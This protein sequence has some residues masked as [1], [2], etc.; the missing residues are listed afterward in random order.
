MH[1][2]SRTILVLILAGIFFTSLTFSFY[3]RISPTTDAKAY[4]RI[5]RNLAAGLGYIEHYEN[6]GD[7]L[8]D[9]AIVRVGPGYEFF[10]AGIYWFLG[11]E[12]WS[13]IWAVQAILRVLT[14]FFIFKLSLLLLGDEREGRSVGIL[15]ALI[16]AVFPDF[17]VVGG[18]LLAETFLMFF[19]II[20]TYY[21]IKLLNT[22]KTSYAIFA[23]F[24]WGVASL[25][26][27]TAIPAVLLLAV[28]LAHRKR[29]KLA[30]V[31]LVFTI[32]FIGGWSLRNSFL[33]GR[34]LFTTTAGSYALWIGNNADATGGYDKTPQIQE[35]VS[36]EHSVELSQK[37]FRDYFAFIIHRPFKFIELQFRKTALYFSLLRPMGFWLYLNGKPI[38]R[39]ITIG[40]SGAF[41]VLLFVFGVAGV[42]RYFRENIREKYFLLG[43]VLLQPVVVIPT[44]VET[45]YRYPFY[46]FLVFFAA[47]AVWLLWNKKITPKIILWVFILFLVVSAIDFLYSGDV[48]IGRFNDIRRESFSSQM[49]YYR[50][51][52]KS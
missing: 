5:A 16:F 44:Y 28:L 30:F 14:A 47:Y 24:F 13:V 46:L 8:R 39:L 23:S 52:V 2:R 25:T 51:H 42:W 43:A 49:R 34:P 3:Y 36:K 10:L 33:Y 29:W 17:I 37:A 35:L 26:R 7:P 15:A 48:F 6:A 31:S 45:R 20:A 27:P 4:T 38:D 12:N 21:S 32:L 40:L 11:G 50:E 22:G 1:M 9:D 19:L 18:M 41:T